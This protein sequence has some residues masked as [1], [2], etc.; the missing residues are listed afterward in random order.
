MSEGKG[1]C[2]GKVSKKLTN[3]EAES[4]RFHKNYSDGAATS[5][6]LR[7]ASQNSHLILSLILIEK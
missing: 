5:G 4:T 1:V 7:I 3:T 2:I 6:G